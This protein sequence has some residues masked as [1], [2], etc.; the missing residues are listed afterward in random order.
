MHMQGFDDGAAV[1]LVKYGARSV[2]AQSRGGAG[3][4]VQ[5]THWLLVT[6]GLPLKTHKPIA[7]PLLLSWLALARRRA[8]FGTSSVPP[9]STPSPFGLESACGERPRSLSSPSPEL[10]Q[11]SSGFLKTLEP[12]RS[13]R[14][15]EGL[16]P[17]LP[18]P[19]CHV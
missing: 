1:F 11:C 7:F 10:P 16:T 17:T 13:R 3:T 19:R 15:T 4:S 2:T 6:T 8:G 12:E 14:R 5:M 9:H 18:L